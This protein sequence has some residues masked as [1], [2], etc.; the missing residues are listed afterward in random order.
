MLKR[1]YSLRDTKAEMFGPL[2]G[3]HRDGEAMR[4][5]DSTVNSQNKDTHVSRNPED[6]RLFLVGVFDEVTGTFTPETPD[7]RFICDALTFVSQE[8]RE[9]AP[10]SK[11]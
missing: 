3:F 2:M 10:L 8:K 6:F 5:L 7:P 11:R 4:A 9:K 1:I